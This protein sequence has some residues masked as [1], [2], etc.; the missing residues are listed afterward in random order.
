MAGKS[1]K[2][3]VSVRKVAYIL[4]NSDEEGSE[5]GVANTEDFMRSSHTV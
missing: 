4:T 2:W 5:K 1:K 3:L